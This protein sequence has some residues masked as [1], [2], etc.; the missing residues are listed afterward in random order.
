MLK[1]VDQEIKDLLKKKDSRSQLDDQEAIELEGVQALL[2][3]LEKQQKR[4]EKEL[5]KAN[6]SDETESVR[7]KD[8][9][10]I[11]IESVCDVDCSHRPWTDIAL[12]DTVEPSARFKENFIET[13]L[14]FHQTGEAGRRIFLNLFL[15]DIVGS[16]PFLGTLKIFT[17]LKLTVSSSQVIED[18]GKKRRLNGFSDYTIG[19][20]KNLDIF[21]EVPPKE[22]H[23]VA[24]EAKCNF[25][26]TD[27]WQCVAET[28]VLYKSRKDAGKKN[29][30]VWG[31]LSNAREWQFIHINESGKLYQLEDPLKLNL[32]RYN[33]EQVNSIYRL[34][35][36]LVK[37]CSESSASFD[38]SV[39]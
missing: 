3:Q 18:T 13:S 14:V 5:S 33:E 1:A 38:L 10:R 22:L 35:Y 30:S 16:L 19:F 27:F 7:L 37:K 31:I 6:K 2:A 34:V 29:L 15:S 8:A 4:W 23:L 17:E 20:G 24:V 9:K 28:A 21:D 32:R 26:E 39:V 11:D 12:D 36:Y 25:L